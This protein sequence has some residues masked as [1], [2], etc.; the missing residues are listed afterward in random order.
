VAGFTVETSGLRA[1][2]KDVASLQ[3]RCQTV[4]HDAV[5]ALTGAAAV[6]GHP[7]VQ[8]AASVMAGK[9]EETFFGAL[10]TYLHLGQSLPSAADG[11][12]AADQTSATA[13]G[14]IPS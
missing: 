13:A 6:A 14:R 4:L 5:S 3:N 12:D 2:A 7:A 10:L 11:Y 8:S 9:G 1:G